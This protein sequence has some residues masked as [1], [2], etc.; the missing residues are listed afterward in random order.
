MR[1]LTLPGA[2]G[3]LGVLAALTFATPVSAHT[4]LSGSSPGDKA[5]VS[6]VEEVV[7]TFNEEVRSARVVVQDAAEKRAHRGTAKID[8]NEVVQKVR[9]NLAPGE[10][11]VGYRVI[12]GD[13]HPVSG[14]LTFTL[15]PGA[16]TTDGA[17][18]PATAS[19]SPSAVADTEGGG[20]RWLMVG[21]GLAAGVGFGLLITMRRRRDA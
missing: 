19:A 9:A 6:A 20:T 10:Y 14:S 4:A 7:L 21:A 2:A 3:A 16:E 1:L 8:G 17:S 13:G 15:K 18:A 5:E 11:T 12:S